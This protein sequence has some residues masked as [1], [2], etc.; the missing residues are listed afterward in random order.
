[1]RKTIVIGLAALLAWNA[2]AQELRGGGA[3]GLPG[4]EGDT[5]ATAQVQVQVQMQQETTATAAQMLQVQQDTTV[6][7]QALQD[8]TIT[9]VQALREPLEQIVRKRSK[10]RRFLPRSRRVDREIDKGHFAYKGEVILGLTASYGTLTSEDTDFMTILDNINLDGAI[11]SVKPFFGYFYRDNR[12]VGIRLGYQHIDGKLG[13]L[14]IDLGEQNDI[15]MNISGMELRS[16]S[17][18]FA[19]FHRSYV[20]IDTKGR[21]GLFAEVEASAQVGTSDFI[22]NSGETLKSTYSDN[23][24]LKL[25]FNPGMAM[26]IFPNVCATV[27]VGLGGLQYNSVEQH[28]AEGNKTGSRSS[29]KMRFRLNIADINFGMVIHL[30]DKKKR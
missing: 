24:R 2:G 5:A 8:T 28:D 14:D 7:A 9:A 3:T 26:Y 10:F 27:S 23:L 22:N 20:G 29:S 6:T 13:N 17:Y 12:C 16:D 21:L 1:M 15:S 18:S 25:S 30:W 4:P 19:L 11:A